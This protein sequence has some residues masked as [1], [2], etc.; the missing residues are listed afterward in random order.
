MLAFSFVLLVTVVFGLFLAALRR[1]ALAV[2][3]TD[4]ASQGASPA[5]GG[6]P[7]PAGHG[8]TAAA[9]IGLAW[10]VLTGA[11]AALGLLS[12]EG[13]PPTM[14][15]ALGTGFALTL[16]LAFSDLGRRIALAVPLIALV[17]FQ[18]FR[19]PLE[20]LMHRAYTDGIMPVQM[21]YSGLNFDI[22]TGITALVLGIAMSTGR[23]PA[24]WVRA[25]NALGFLLLLTI[26][27]IAML[28]APLPFRVFMND[29]ANVWITQFP[30]IWLPAV[31]VQAALLGHILVIRRLRSGS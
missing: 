2:R 25:W 24:G 29:P 28:S 9:A 20:L 27:G 21:S 5:A 31:L 10:I 6:D 3:P 14:M 22:I 4:A 7:V 1:T 23:V 16:T 12:F 30:F 15:L 18:A 26:I 8:T 19:L 13:T 17:G 11:M